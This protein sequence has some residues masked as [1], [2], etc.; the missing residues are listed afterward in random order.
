[1][2]HSFGN[3]GVEFSILTTVASNEVWKLNYLVVQGLLV[4]FKKN[5]GFFSL[6]NKTNKYLY[7][8]YVPCARHCFQDLY[9]H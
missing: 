1:M 4:R 9:I 7:N 6:K 2:E 8:V 3:S 5:Y